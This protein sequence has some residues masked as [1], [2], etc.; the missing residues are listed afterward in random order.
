MF[1][2]P[3]A[4]MLPT[5]CRLHAPF[6]H[7]LRVSAPALQSWAQPGLYG[8]CGRG[9]R[10]RRLLCAEPGKACSPQH[11]L[12]AGHQRLGPM[13]VVQP[14]HF[15]ISPMPAPHSS[16]ARTVDDFQRMWKRKAALRALKVGR[17]WAWR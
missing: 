6:L 12:D 5:S 2:I 16:V 3:D 8:M 10:R 15:W 7:G 1:C 4:S 14:R 11:H 9:C 17:D 13:Q